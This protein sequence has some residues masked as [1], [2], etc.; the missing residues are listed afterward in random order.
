MILCVNLTTENWLTVISLAFAAIGGA[1][2]YLQWQKTLKAKRAEFINQILEKIIFDEELQKT[3]Y[4]IDY[5]QNWYSSRFHTSELEPSV[6]KLFSYVDY[7]CYL[8]STGNISKTEFKIFQY[9]L[10]R[11]C[12]SDSSKAYLWNLYNFSMKNNATPLFQ[13]LIEYGIENNLFP[14]DFKSNKELYTKTL[15]W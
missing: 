3:M 9:E 2:I 6:D 15:N 4:S 13:H 12:I 5:D 7:I 8:K 11:I 14:N 10:N 1:F